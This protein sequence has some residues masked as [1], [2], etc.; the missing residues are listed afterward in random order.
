MTVKII[1]QGIFF[2]SRKK[3]YFCSQIMADNMLTK[4][5]LYNGQPF[6]TGT[7]CSSTGLTSRTPSTQNERGGVSV[8]NMPAGKQKWFVLRVSY[9]RLA[10]AKAFVEAKQME[11]YAPLRYKEIRKHGKCHI[12][13]DFLLPSFLFVRATRCEI[14][15]LLRVAKSNNVEARKPLLSFYYDHISNLSGIPNRNPPLVIPDA[16]MANFIRLTSI[17]TPNVIPVTS[18]NIQFKLGDMVVVTQGE[19]QGI[20]GRVTRIAGQQRVIVELF[21]G[22]LVATAYVPKGAMK[23]LI[24]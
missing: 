24:I 6:D 19:F 18:P 7:P 5:S 3:S 11:C 2:S 23:K 8:E 16:A 15:A 1:F 21:D 4:A 17:Q 20:R 12:V 14:D 22:C 9:A 10:K 13:T